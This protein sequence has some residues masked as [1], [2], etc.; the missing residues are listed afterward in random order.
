M[1]VAFANSGII[2]VTPNVLE[3][4]IASL[5]VSKWKVLKTASISPYGNGNQGNLPFGIDAFADT[6]IKSE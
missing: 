3:Q 1:H 2:V 5:A 6:A 4:A